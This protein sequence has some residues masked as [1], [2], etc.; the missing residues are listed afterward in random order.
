MNNNYPIDELELSRLKSIVPDHVK[1]ESDLN[2]SKNF[3]Q[4]K[5][6]GNDKLMLLLRRADDKTNP[7]MT[8]M[9]NSD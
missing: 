8:R 3:L 1:C 5:M 6:T 7:M 2:K 4:L 9:T